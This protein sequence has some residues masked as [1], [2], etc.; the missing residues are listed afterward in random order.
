MGLTHRTP[1]RPSALRVW[2]RVARA[3]LASGG[4]SMAMKVRMESVIGL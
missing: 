1:E 3:S 2:V 4:T